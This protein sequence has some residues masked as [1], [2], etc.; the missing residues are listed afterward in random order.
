M[1]PSLMLPVLSMFFASSLSQADPDCPA[2][3]REGV[4]KAHP[5]ATIRICK[6]EMED[7]RVQWMVRI[8]EKSRK[9][10]LDVSPGGAILQTEEK[11]PLSDV[12]SAVTKAFSAK[13]PKLRVIR[14]E[15]QTRADGSASFELAFKEGDKRREATF[16]T[17][18]RFVEEE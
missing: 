16:T 17:K 5:E 15:K 10:E 13:Y 12:P 14:A 9:L 6:R 11:I 4:A 3:V 7:G 2:P 8:D 18:G 1:K